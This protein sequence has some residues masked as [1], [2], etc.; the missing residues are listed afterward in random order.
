MLNKKIIILYFILINSFQANAMQITEQAF[1]DNGGD[2]VNIDRTI[3]IAFESLREESYSEPYLAVGKIS[4]LTSFDCTGVWL[5]NDIDDDGKEW[6]YI[7]TLAKCNGEVLAEQTEVKVKNFSFT[8]WDKHVIAKGEGSFFL[9]NDQTVSSSDIGIFKLP[10]IGALNNKN[11]VP[12][13][14]PILYAGR[15][16]QYKIFSFVGYG[17]LEV[18]TVMVSYTPSDGDNRH[19]GQSV[20]DYIGQPNTL[21]SDYYVLDKT[22]RWAK[23]TKKDVE[24]TTWWQYIQGRN[25]I[26]AIGL[27]ANNY[28]STGASISKYHQWIETIYSKARF[29]D[30]AVDASDIPAK[31]QFQMV[32]CEG[33]YRRC[34]KEKVT[35]DQESYIKLDSPVSAQFSYSKNHILTDF[36]SEAPKWDDF[37]DFYTVSEEPAHVKLPNNGYKY[38]LDKVCFRDEQGNE[39]SCA[40]TH[41]TSYLD[42][43][44][45]EWGD[46]KSP[47]SGKLVP[48]QISTQTFPD[49]KVNEIIFEVR[50]VVRDKNDFE[51]ELNSP[52][53]VRYKFHNS[54]YSVISAKFKPDGKGGYMAEKTDKAHTVWAASR[55][56]FTL[57]EVCLNYENDLVGT[58]CI[59]AKITDGSWWGGYKGQTLIYPKKP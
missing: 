52:K 34:G 23:T 28:F 46:F 36:F 47:T 29:S 16:E 4:R 55:Y 57:D 19:W 51:V 2:I 30:T 22:S 1:I 31:A 33:G 48:V 12:L 24:G 38:T 20:I 14:K 53:S 37:N 17:P 42:R 59:N 39:T 21:L 35:I 43:T 58:R 6:A 45:V 9:P 50:V 15:D 40:E 10:K 11:G 7:L 56:S 26:S 25:V 44:S 13:Q 32:R 49:S 18:D 54:K 5:G 27:N 3:G 41:L 8:S